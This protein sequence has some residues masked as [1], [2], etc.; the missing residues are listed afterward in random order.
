M[1]M[2]ARFIVYAGLILGTFLGLNS[3]PIETAMLIVVAAGLLSV[4]GLRLVK[5]G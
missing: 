1:K 5:I 4:W 2:K 3:M